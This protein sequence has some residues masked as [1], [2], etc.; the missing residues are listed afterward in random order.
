MSRRRIGS[1]GRRLSYWLALQSLVGLIAVCA[2][3]Y[4][5]AQVG[6]EARQ[7][8]SLQQKQAQLRH[9]LA[10]SGED[11][12]TLKHKLDEFFIGHADMA[13]S[14]TRS[15]GSVL[16]ARPAPANSVRAVRFIS[17]V[18]SPNQ[19]PLVALLTLDIRDDVALLRRIGFTLAV[20]ALA[21]TLFVSVGG[22]LLVRLSLQPLRDLVEQTR[23]LAAD[24]LHR[25]LDGSA[26]P[27]ELEPLIT[28]FNGLLGRLELAYEQLEGFN[29]DVAHEL[30]T[31]L[32]TLIGSTELALRKARDASELRDVLGSNLEE[33]QRIAG[34]VHDMLFLSQAD[35]GVTARRTPTPSLAALARQVSN[36]HEASLADAGLGLEIVG[37]ADGSF[38]TP[39]LQRALSNLISNA[40]RYGQRGSTVRVEISKESS[41]EVVLKVVNKGATIDSGDL[42]RLF[43][44]FYR[45]D[46][47]RSDAHR[48]HG[49]GL[50]I[51]AAIA[52]MHGGRP[53]AASSG[54]ISSIGMTLMDKDGLSGSVKAIRTAESSASPA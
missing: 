40:T 49:L 2:A 4:G 34:I 10:E 51:V 6:F 28:Q 43:D 7:T 18:Q 30:C 19:D 46:P 37:D 12:G 48:N 26:Q 11:M 8:D 14:L 36:Y 3:V 23:R 42:P 27:D 25:R 20:A 22:F 16:Y 13:L 29:A 5:A 45:A 52:R 35:R 54:G 24:T 9:L 32:T 17:P 33:L 38:D 21:G 39:L 50:S 53:L 41:G 15:D 47:S 44:R 31:P 1:L